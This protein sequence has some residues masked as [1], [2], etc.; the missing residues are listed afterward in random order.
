[1]NINV[2]NYNILESVTGNEWQKFRISEKDTQQ[3]IKKSIEGQII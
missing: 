3:N 1:M 2:S